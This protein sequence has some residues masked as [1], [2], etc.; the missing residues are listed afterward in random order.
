M[1]AH[2]FVLVNLLNGLGKSDTMRGLPSIYHF[3][4]TSLINMGTS[5]RFL[6][7]CDI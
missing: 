3:F 4:T 5:V 2:V 6:L 7:S 1:S